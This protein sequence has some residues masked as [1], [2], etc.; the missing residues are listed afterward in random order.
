MLHHGS[1][2]VASPPV[3]YIL[4]W[5]RGYA[6]PRAFRFPRGLDIELGAYL[7]TARMR[8]QMHAP[9]ASCEPTSS[10][11][12]GPGSGRDSCPTGIRLVDVLGEA[13]CADARQW[14]GARAIR[15]L[16]PRMQEVLRLKFHEGL[17]NAEIA[18]RLGLHPVLR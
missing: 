14:D 16:P 9:Y 1:G 6:G 8:A 12:T 3:R 11:C 18:V 2:L 4:K 7:Q 13:R 5:G 15:E 10:T 17:K